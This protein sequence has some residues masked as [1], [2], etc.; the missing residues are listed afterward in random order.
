MDR[1][2]SESGGRWLF[3]TDRAVETDVEIE[4]HRVTLMKPLTY[5]NLSGGPVAVWAR[6]HAC[7]RSEVV[8]Y[9]DDVALPLGT[10]RL[11]ERGSDGGHRGLASILEALGGSDVPRVRIGIRPLDV[12]TPPGELADFVLSSFAP[13]ERR[14]VD[15]TLDRV[16]SATRSLLTEGMGKAMARF[17]GTSAS[18]SSPVGGSEGGRLA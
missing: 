3:K 8:V 4:G 2:L 10:L 18:G 13:E 5:M 16:V 15:E 17:N 12:E 7:E 6:E 9:F 1:L 11:R 14:V